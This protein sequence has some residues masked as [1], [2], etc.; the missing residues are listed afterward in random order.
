MK[1]QRKTIKAA[2]SKDKLEN[3]DV[4]LGMRDAVPLM[5]QLALTKGCDQTP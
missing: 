5:G 2:T 4:S 3:A 1:V